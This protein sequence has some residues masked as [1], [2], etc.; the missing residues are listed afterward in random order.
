[1]PGSAMPSFAHLSETDRRALVAFIKKLANIEEKPERVISIPSEPSVTSKM[2]AQ[3]K[4]L[5]IKM[6]CWQ[7]HGFEGT[8]DGP[9]AN[10]L[11]D[12]EGFPIPPND[13]T[14][15]IFKGGG[16]SSDIYLRFTAGMDGTPMPS[17]ED[18]LNDAQRWAL[19]HYVKSLVGSKVVVQPSTGTI[20]ARKVPG[21]LPKDALDPLWNKVPA[22]TI[23]LIHL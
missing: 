4:E 13:F 18:T 5:Y 20:V 9:S 21:P 14:R 10:Q 2:L 1:M 16:R 6:K 11:V 23:P 7:C 15:G 19:A 17:Y 8:G 12:D 3:G 22:T